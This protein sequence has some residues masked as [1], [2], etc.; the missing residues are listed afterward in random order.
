MKRVLEYFDFIS[1][2]L[3]LENLILESN[4]V[5]SPKFKNILSKMKASSLQNKIAQSLL[6]IE[7]QDLDVTV[8]DKFNILILLTIFLDISNIVL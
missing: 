2:K 7:E 8:L 5:Y 4:V 6:E 1:E 3:L